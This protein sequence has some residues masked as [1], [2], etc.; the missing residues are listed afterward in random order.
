MIEYKGTSFGNEAALLADARVT[1]AWHPASY[2]IDLPTVRRK[3]DLPDVIAVDW[4]QRIVA[5]QRL[6][7]V[8]I[9][10]EKTQRLKASSM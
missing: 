1:L 10:L 9:P 7:R 4:A 5:P 6:H 3:I 8:L 2:E